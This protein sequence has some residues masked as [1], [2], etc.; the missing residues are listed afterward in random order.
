MT[1]LQDFNCQAT[2][3]YIFPFLVVM[4]IGQSVAGMIVNNPPGRR[5]TL[6][7]GV[8][9]ALIVSL[10]VG[11]LPVARWLI[12]FNANFSIPLT[13]VL[14]GKVWENA[15]GV[16]LFDSRALMTAWIFGLTAG[17]IL[18]PMGL[19][20]GRFDPYI[21]GWQYSSLFLLLFV[22]TLGLIFTKNRFGAVLV[23]CMLA[24][25][26]RLLESENLWDY[27][28]G[29]FYMI[30]SAILLGFRWKNSRS[31]DI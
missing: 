24:Y 23:G 17:I 6:I 1:L 14:L 15:T 27:L 2:V 5:L 16:K 30:A 11:G 18:Y 9:S 3:S 26:L 4:V 31:L 12:S 28:V 21:L 29:P 22:V 8:L 19:G 10:P 20:L 7:L 25:N 13:A